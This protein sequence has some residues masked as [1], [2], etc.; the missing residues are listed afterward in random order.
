MIKLIKIIIFGFLI[1]VS[2][3]TVYAKNNQLI[4]KQIECSIQSNKK[5][6]EDLIL[7]VADTE[8][9]RSYG[10]MNRK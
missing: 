8:Q 2:V 3:D 4:F 10:L 9:K 5:K 7:D 6:Y 1:S